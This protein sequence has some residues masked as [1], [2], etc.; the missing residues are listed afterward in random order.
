MFVCASQILWISWISQISYISLHQFFLDFLYFLHVLYVFAFIR[1][2]LF[3][4]NSQI[5]YICFNVSDSF[6]FFNGL[7]RTIV[8]CL[9]FIICLRLVHMSQIS[10]IILDFVFF[11]DFLYLSIV[12]TSKISLDFLDFFRFRT[13]LIFVGCVFILLRFGSKYYI[14]WISQISH[15]ALECLNF[16]CFLGFVDFLIVFALF[17]FLQIFCLISY[18]GYRCPAFFL[19]FLDLFRF[20][21]FVCTFYIIL[22][23]QFSYM[24]FYFFFFIFLKIGCTYDLNL[25]SQSYQ[26]S[27]YFVYF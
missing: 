21:K 15:I 26:S 16:K 19:D 24:Y 3:S 7:R 14:V 20:L 12:C 27:L 17:R 13:C 2:L 8:Y 23:Y 18:I 4:Y 9:R 22:I 10:L 1:F 25:I 6:D 5:S 11:I